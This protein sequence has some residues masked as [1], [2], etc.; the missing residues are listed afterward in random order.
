MI[1]LPLAGADPL[2]LDLHPVDWGAVALASAIIFAIL[3]RRLLAD[4]RR[5]L[6]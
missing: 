2:A 5:W 3:G 4:L 6:G 1:H